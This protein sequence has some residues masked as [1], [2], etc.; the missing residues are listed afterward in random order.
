MSSLWERDLSDLEG[1][2]PAPSRRPELRG[3]WPPPHPPP[4]LSCPS[5]TGQGAWGPAACD[6]E[7]NWVGPFSGILRNLAQSRADLP[8]PSAEAGLG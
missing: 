4:D 8:Q 5:G 3:L 7:G 2:G 6:L 1:A